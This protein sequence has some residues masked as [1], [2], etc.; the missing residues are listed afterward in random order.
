VG[1]GARAA[2]YLRDTSAPV[3]SVGVQFR[4]GGATALLGVPAAELAGRHTPLDDLWGTAAPAIR[5]RL[6]SARGP[7]DGLRI[8]ADVLRERRAQAAAVHPAVAHALA[9]LEGAGGRAT[10]AALAVETGYSQRRFI[11]LFHA[12][13]GLRPKEFARVRRFQRALALAANARG[14]G[15]AGIAAACGFADQSH[16][17]REFQA[18]AGMPPGAWQPVGWDR[19]NHVP[20]R[21]WSR[22]SKTAAAR[23]G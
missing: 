5:D 10:T 20:E 23:A 13:V 21:D 3:R 16:L 6:A 2:F 11:E 4:P 19:P 1:G 7:A 8:L 18:L 14:R 9:R 12:A 17:V 22:T 15:W